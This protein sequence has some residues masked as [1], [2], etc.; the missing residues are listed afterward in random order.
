MVDA[1]DANLNDSTKQSVNTIALNSNVDNPD[2]ARH[3]S[4]LTVKSKS[5]RKRGDSGAMDITELDTNIRRQKNVTFEKITTVTLRRI[6][7]QRTEAG[8]M[9]YFAGA[10][11]RGS[12]V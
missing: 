7:P 5:K 3:Q 8:V 9:M 10:A 12:H 4:V 6:H 1:D 2:D 11:A